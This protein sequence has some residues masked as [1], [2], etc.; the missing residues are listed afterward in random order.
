ME[1]GI[2]LGDCEHVVIAGCGFSMTACGIHLTGCKHVTVKECVISDIISSDGPLEGYGI[3][4][5]SGAYHRLANNRFKRMYKPCI[6]LSAGCSYSAVEG[7]VS[8]GSRDIMISLSSQLT[9]CTRN[10]ISGNIVPGLGLA[11]GET[12]CI[13]GIRLKDYCTENVIEDNIISQASQAGIVLLGEGTAGDDRPYGNVIRGNKI[14][15][16]PTGI[17]LRNTDGNVVSGNDV[18]RTGTGVLLDTFGEDDGAYCRQNTVT[19]NTLFRCQA[20]GIRLDSSRRQGNAVFGNSG[21]NNGEP[22]KNL[23]TDTVTGGF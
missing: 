7:N 12:S 17:W 16:G 23:G 21:A 13:H 20:E 19:Q 6:H 15:G 14:D 4:A 2:E 5:E 22:V 10:R 8:E 11:D 9:P 3:V 1:R 18:R